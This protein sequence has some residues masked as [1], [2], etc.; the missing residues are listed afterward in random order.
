MKIAFY[1][2]KKGNLLD[3]IIDLVSTGYGY[4]HV[5]ILFDFSSANVMFSSYP[6]IGTGFR[7]MGNANKS[8]WVFK[9]L[10]EITKEQELEIYNKCIKINGKKYDY[11]GILFWFIVHLRK[12]DENKWWCS[13]VVGY[14][15]S[16]YP[17][18]EKYFSDKEFRITPNRMA[19]RFKINKA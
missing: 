5:E 19:K 9:D 11:F 15:L 6:G 18:L 17:S 2:A 12:Q 4:S 8:E 7:A 3:R 13:E 14:I 16:D 10:P 1:K